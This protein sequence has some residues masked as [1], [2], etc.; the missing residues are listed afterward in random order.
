M[1]LEACRA[2]A[3]Y[4]RWMNGKVYAAA[5]RLSDDERKR[6][7]GAFFGSIHNVL[8]HILV[9]DRI[10]LGRLTARVPEPGFIGVDQEISSDFDQLCRE[11]DRTDGE[12]DDWTA[13]L[14][15]DSLAGTFRLARKGEPRDLPVWWAVTQLFNHQTHHRGQITTLLFQAGQDP[16]STDVFA[17]LN[18][19]ARSPENAR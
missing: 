7:R 3:R 12:I 10:W 11:R 17:M 8:N 2:F 16:G 15:A 6:D 14:T 18:E 4:N 5:A 19:E 9:A 1:M 13:T